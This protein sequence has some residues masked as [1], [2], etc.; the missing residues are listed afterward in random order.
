M[1]YLLAYNALRN[2]ES[3]VVSPITNV[4]DLNWADGRMKIYC[5]YLATYLRSTYPVCRGWDNHT[6]TSYVLVSGLY[7]FQ[8]G[9]VSFLERDLNP[10][11]NY[12]TILQHFQIKYFQHICQDIHINY[13]VWSHIYS[14]IL[15][16]LLQRFRMR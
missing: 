1:G 6:W 12:V 9:K 11:L 5:G 14:S 15:Y 4:F 7:S 16:K 2:T 13:K 3:C 10:S 8:T